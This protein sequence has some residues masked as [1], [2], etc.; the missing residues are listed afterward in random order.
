[1]G[2]QEAAPTL[3]GPL[4]S[5]CILVGTDVEG[6]ERARTTAG[7]DIGSIGLFLSLSWWRGQHRVAASIETMRERKEETQGQVTSWHLQSKA[8]VSLFPFAKG[9]DFYKLFFSTFLP[10]ASRVLKN[11]WASFHS[12]TVP[13]PRVI[14][15]I[16]GGTQARHE[17]AVACTMTKWVPFKYSIRLLIISKR[18]PALATLFCFPHSA[19]SS[20]N[21]PKG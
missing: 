12:D 16:L 6:E 15:L 10:L 13:P 17:T 4:G 11:H 21:I 9:N 19:E 14:R 18:S 8:F 2:L 20:Q 5:Y 7:A 3:R 1:M